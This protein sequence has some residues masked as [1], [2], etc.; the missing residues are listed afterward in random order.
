MYSNTN[1]FSDTG[2]FLRIKKTKKI[3]KIERKIGKNM[4]YDVMIFNKYFRKH[5][6]VITPVS[7]GN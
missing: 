6:S 3:N 1:I 4:V 2:W 5:F 7:M